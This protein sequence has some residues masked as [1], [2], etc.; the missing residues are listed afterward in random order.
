[1]NIKDY[2][3]TLARLITINEKEYAY[4]KVDGQYKTYCPYC[5]KYSLLS[6][7]EFKKVRSE[8]K[9][10]S[11]GES[12]HNTTHTHLHKEYYDAVYLIEDGIETGYHINSSWT[13]GEDVKLTRI[14]KYSY[15]KDGKTYVKQG[16]YLA[17]MFYTM[18]VG[19][20]FNQVAD[21]WHKV[22]SP[23]YYNTS[24]DYYTKWTYKYGT[25]KD[26]AKFLADIYGVTKSTQVKIVFENDLDKELAMALGV[27]DLNSLEEFKQ[28][29]KYLKANQTHMDDFVKDKIKLNIHYLDYLA[30]NNIDLGMYYV[31]L[32]DLK[33]L[34][35]KYEKPTDFAYR[36]K[37]VGEMASASKDAEINHKVLDRFNSLPKYQSENITIKPFSTAHEIRRCGKVLHCCIGGYV[38]SYA[39]KK[40]DIYHLDL[41]GAIKVAIEI[42]DG[43]LVQARA[44]HNAVCPNDLYEHIKLFCKAN[45]FSE[46]V[47]SRSRIA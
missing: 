31:F 1:M 43:R 19:C 6:P 18:K 41:D 29:E 27:F 32:S 25:R 46:N 20:H 22:E 42:K 33:Q 38:D 14:D 35:F 3:Q 40:T 44:D 11:C 10:P 4:Q 47:L 17:G 12:F 15:K 2:Q 28:Y 13:F 39:T 45:N 36:S 37:V 34:G 16:Y 26:R 30:R 23:N 21:K 9:C 5:Q 24:F 7:T 8:K